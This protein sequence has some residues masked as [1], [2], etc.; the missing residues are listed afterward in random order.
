MN[1]AQK[2]KTKYHSQV[3][4]K[5]YR[6]LPVKKEAEITELQYKLVDGLIE[7]SNTIVSL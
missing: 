2:V 7:E 6:I 5:A 1:P 4:Q 3:Q